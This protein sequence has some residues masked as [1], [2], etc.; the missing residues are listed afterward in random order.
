MNIL[1][2]FVISIWGWVEKKQGFKGLF[3]KMV[4]LNLVRQEALAA[5]SW[6]VRISKK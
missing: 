2:L 3:L 4:G 1:I 5:I 6:E